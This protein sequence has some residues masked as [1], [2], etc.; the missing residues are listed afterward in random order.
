MPF[1]FVGFDKYKE[2]TELI[3]TLHITYTYTL[4]EV[5]STS[6]III[7]CKFYFELVI[8]TMQNPEMK[9]GAFLLFS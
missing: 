4:T 3:Y 8:Q 6:N 5:F 7:M 9:Y 2:A 1:F